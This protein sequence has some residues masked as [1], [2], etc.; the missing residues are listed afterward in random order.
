[1]LSA[2]PTIIEMTPWEVIEEALARRRPPRNQEWLA[3]QLSKLSGRTV[4]PQGVSNWKTRGVPPARHGELADLFGLTT[5][6]IAGRAPLPWETN[7]GWPFPGIEEARFLR[8]DDTQKGEI[9]GEV[10]RMIE[11]FERSAS[12]KSA[13][14]RRAA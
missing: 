14:S 5:D 2:V 13:G 1:M 6:Q 11:R 7:T 8:L 3:E 4:T 10:R 12:G 9:Q